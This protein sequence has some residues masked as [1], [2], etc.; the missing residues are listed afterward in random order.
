MSK[1]KK[2]AL[3]LS[4]IEANAIMVMLETEIEACFD[5]CFNPVSEWETVDI[6]AYKLLGYQKFKKWYMETHND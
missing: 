1:N 4:P 6:M 5:Y 2:P 3:E